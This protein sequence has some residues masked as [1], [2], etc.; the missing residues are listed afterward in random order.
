MIIRH[1]SSLSFQPS[2]LNA[3]QLPGGAFLT[4]RIPDFKLMIAL[5]LCYISATVDQA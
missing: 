5:L 4:E 2:G 3:G 1:Y